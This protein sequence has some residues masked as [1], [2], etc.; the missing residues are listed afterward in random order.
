MSG[1]LLRKS[2]SA[3]TRGTSSRRA[4]RVTATVEP[5]TRIVAEIPRFHFVQRTNA[6]NGISKT[7]ARKIP[8]KT[9]IS[10]SRIEITAAASAATAA[11]RSRVRNGMVRAAARMSFIVRPPTRRRAPRP[12]QRDETPRSPHVGP[13]PTPVRD[14]A[15]QHQDD[16]EREQTSEDAPR[17]ER[18]RDQEQDDDRHDRDRHR[19][20]GQLDPEAEPHS[21]IKQDCADGR[22]IQR[23]RRN[24]AIV[25]EA[26]FDALPA[27]YD[28][29]ARKALVAG[30]NSNSRSAGAPATGGEIAWSS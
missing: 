14:P 13:G 6:R 10:V 27:S 21:R 28:R 23:C 2:R 4:S 15:D 11:A 24:R 16:R 8:R 7:S 1:R 29:P 20:R 12:R 25:R 9:R 18:L 22:N 5:S 19:E 17:D 26:V 30:Q 3:P